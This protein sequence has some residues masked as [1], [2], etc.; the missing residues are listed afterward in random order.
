MK[1]VPER[2]S[3]LGELYKE[4]NSVYKNNY[5]EF[6]PIMHAMFPDG[7]KLET[8]EEFN[9]IGIFVQIV[10]KIARYAKAIKERGQ[11]DSLDDISIYCQMLREYND[12][13][14]KESRA[15]HVDWGY[16][17]Q[18]ELELGEDKRELRGG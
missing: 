7:L 17:S 2:L 14:E 18:R 12:I 10:A 6:G 4:R 13:K 8:D 3:D 1:T 11:Q 9:R 5:L 15:V 16:K